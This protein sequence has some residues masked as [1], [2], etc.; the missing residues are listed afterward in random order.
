MFLIYFLSGLVAFAMWFSVIYAAI[1]LA[2]KHDRAMRVTAVPPPSKLDVT[3]QTQPS[4]GPS[5]ATQ[6][7]RQFE[8][9]VQSAR[10]VFAVFEALVRSRPS[11]VPARSGEP[12]PSRSSR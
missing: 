5:H 4:Q 11:H 12:V 8:R 9:M 2:L 3:D 1:G 7:M 6:G 10:P